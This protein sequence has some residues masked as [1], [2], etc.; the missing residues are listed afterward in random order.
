MEGFARLSFAT[1]REMINKGIDRFGAFL[2]GEVGALN[3]QTGLSQN[4]PPSK[5]A[6]VQ[7][8]VTSS[9]SVAAIWQS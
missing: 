3:L 1:S 8:T 9:S 6:V 4:G 7:K 5:P 2:R